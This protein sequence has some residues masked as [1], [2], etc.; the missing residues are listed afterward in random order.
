ME[1]FFADKLSLVVKEFQGKQIVVGGSFAISAHR[2]IGR[3]VDASPRLR[4]QDY[5]YCCIPGATLE[6]FRVVGC[7]YISVYLYI[8]FFPK[9]LAEPPNLGRLGANALFVD[10]TPAF[11][12][13]TISPYCNLT[14]RHCYFYKGKRSDDRPLE[15]DKC[16]AVLDA[17]SAGGVRMVSFSG[18]EPLLMKDIRGVLEYAKALSLKAILNSNLT[19]ANA[20][21]IE[22]LKAVQVDMVI[23]SV[24]SSQSVVHDSL[25][26]GGSF[27]KTL[28]AISMSVAR[29]INIGINTAVTKLNFRGLRHLV[30]FAREC[31]VS[32]VKFEALIPQGRA[33][34]N[35]GLLAPDIADY[36]FIAEE[37]DGI[38]DEYFNKIPIIIS[39]VFERI[40]EKRINFSCPSG[41]LFFTVTHRGDLAY[42]PSLIEE[43]ATP[44]NLLERPLN[45]CL[46]LL[47]SSSKAQYESKCITCDYFTVCQSG[48]FS[49]SFYDRGDIWACDPLCELFEAGTI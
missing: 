30:D 29:G 5:G 40:V 21:L 42:C 18:G 6:K 32:F 31:G 17:I 37:I 41:K 49:R 36:R 47:R 44:Y 10:R 9:E 8:K 15:Y 43:S 20:E 19:R 48:C 2:I 4:Q 39:N 24:E 14:C 45:E 27:G 38:C 12:V 3:I 22:F 35:Y 25:R 33:A 46:A 7:G 11:V 16:C 28:N 26:G 13:W 34:D 1:S 23:T